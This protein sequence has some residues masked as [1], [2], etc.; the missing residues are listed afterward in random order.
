VR[1][2]QSAAPI[3]ADWNPPY[4][5][6]AERAVLGSV[7]LEN[8]AL[9]VAD[10]LITA[11]AMS[12]ENGV[13]FTAMRSLREDGEP[14]DLVTL[15]A[16]LLSLKKLN[17]V[18]G[19]GYLSQILSE[20]PTAAN[21]EFYAREVRRCWLQRVGFDLIRN[22]YQAV[23]RH[24]EPAQL[25]AAM[26]AAAAQFADQTSTGQDFRDMRDVMAETY[27]QLEARSLNT[28]G[29]TG[30][31][32]GY[33]ELDRLTSGFQR[34][35]LI[36]VAA[37]PS[38]GKTAFALNI[39]QHA[40]VKCGEAVAI[41]SLE[42]SA[43]Q[44]GQRF[45]A[46]EGHIDASRIRTGKLDFDDWKKVPLAISALSE[47]G[48][49]I[50][51]TP[52]ISISDI[53]AKCRRLKKRLGHLG[54]VII[55]YL[56]LV[57]VRGR[58]EN[59]VQEVSEISRILKR[60]AREL[61]VPVIALSQLSRK[62]EERQDKRPMLSDLRESGSIEQDADV[63]AFLYRDDYYDRETERKNIL[64]IIVAKQRNGPVGTVELVF[65]KNFNRFVS[66]DRYHVLPEKDRSGRPIPDM[67]RGMHMADRREAEA[68]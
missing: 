38:I 41:F 12:P 52:G 49:Y 30:V 32:S 13:I 39:A 64:E 62:V 27:D 44:L 33:D 31:P 50:D 35:D 11:D 26:E 40:G 66:L 6:E 23:L 60:I 29:I 5:H 21:V 61:D 15:T 45:L 34:S 8:N 9:D 63:V 59:R 57:T 43:T 7:L 37:R 54:L 14:I 22:L 67:H 51:D 36:I 10:A 2:L 28:T 48:I 3:D 20:V 65:L 25:S 19:V 58:R 68:R 4:N 47:A 18:G 53:R 56:Q 16:R 55:D 24:E 17:Q 46:S 1:S 42:M